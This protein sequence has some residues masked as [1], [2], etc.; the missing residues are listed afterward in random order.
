MIRHPIC[1]LTANDQPLN[2][3]ITSR[4]INVT[5][6]DNRASEADE[7]S[8]TLDDH[9]GALELPKRGVMLTCH[10]GWSDGVHDM[11]SFKVDETEWAGT[12]DTITI[13]A[14]AADFTSNLKTGKRKSYHR[15][16]LGQIAGTIAKA[17]DLNLTISAELSDIDLIHVDQTD[18]SD[19]NLLSRLAQQNG[20]AV[21]IKKGKLLIFKAGQAKTASGK[22]LP[23]IIVTRQ[24]GDQFR[25][26]EADRDSNYTGVSASWHEQGK[27][28]RK[29]TTAGNPEVKGGGDDPKTKVLK[30]TFANEA[31]A[32]R[33]ASAELDRIKQ[34]KATF[35]LTLAEGKPDI[36]SEHPVALLGFKPA[37][38]A[39]NWIVAKATHSYSTS[40]LTTALELE[41]NV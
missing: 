38:D 41:A 22:T 15:Q 25:Y 11:G 40:G 13:K 16:T 32:Q 18:E 36:S 26:S 30:G 27:A 5:V 1:Q 9:D 19:L 34:Q 4:I 24:D 28:K 17:H 31:E 23:K 2:A 37:I 21:T 35:N 3:L 29:R 8:I 6:T 39:L 7:L 12:P 14:R 33:A 10:L 20:A